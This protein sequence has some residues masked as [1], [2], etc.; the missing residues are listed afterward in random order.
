MLEEIKG[1]F[2]EGKETEILRLY[3]KADLLVIDDLGKELCTDW[4]ISTLYNIINDR[5]EEMRPIIVTTN[6]NEEVLLKNLTPKGGD[7]QKAKAILSRLAEVSD[8]I[9]MA[10]EDYRRK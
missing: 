2:A 7:N 4:S 10:G 8:V 3:K 5:Y 6:F 9:T 1:S